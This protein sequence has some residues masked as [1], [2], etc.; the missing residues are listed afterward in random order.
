MKKFYTIICLTFLT[1]FAFSQENSITGFV[2][3]N[4]SGDP[5][6]AA[7]VVVKETQK[8]TVTA[9]NGYFEI[10]VSGDASVI[11]QVTY[12][13]YSTIEIKATPGEK[14]IIINMEPS[15]IMGD[16]VVVS[17]SRFSENI[18]TAPLTI[19]KINERQIESAPSGDYFQSLGNLRDVEIINN[20][21]GFKIFNSRGFNTTA[22][23][24]VVQ[25]I[26]GIDNQLPTINIVPGNMFGVSDI[27][28]R[29][30]EV[31]SGPASALYGPNAMQGVISYETKNPYDFPGVTVKLKGGNREYF[32]GQFRAAS[33]FIN[34]KLGVK[35]AGSYMK[36][37]DWQSDYIYGNQPAH[38]M[39][40]QDIMGQMLQDPSYSDF[41]NYFT[42]VDQNTAPF[43]KVIMPGYS[44]ED[45]FN[46]KIDNMKISG[47]L[48]Y[49]FSKDIQAK[50]VYRYSTGTSL[51]M[52]NNRAPLDGFYQQLHSLEFKGKGFTFHAYRSDD[53][54][55]DTYTLVGAGVNLGF[56]SLG[57]VDA[58]F[59][60]AYVNEIQSLSN[61][62]TNTLTPEQLTQAIAAGSTASQDSWLEPGT[63]T[64]NTAYDKIKET[65]PP[66]G[67]HYSS[68]T[69]LY[70][71]GGMYEYS[72]EKIDLNVGGSY[73]NTKPVSHGSVFAD[74]LQQDGS[75]RQIDVSEYG[76]FV[77]GIGHIS[78]GKT[79]LYASIRM[80]KSKN[81]DWQFSPRIAVVTTAGNNN[82]RLTL[83]SAFRAPAVSDQYQYLNRGRDI[84]LG[85]VDG[86]GNCY[87][88]SSIDS[89][90]ANGKDPALLVSTFVAAV[91]PEQVKSIE[92]GYN[93]IFGEKLYVDFSAYFSMYSDFIAYQRVGRPGFGTAGEPSG[94]IAMDTNNY[95][96]YSVAT[97]VEQDVNTYGASIGLGYYFS[98]KIMA[99]VNYTYSNIDSAGIS[100]DVIPGFNTPKHKVNMGLEGTN[101][102][103]NL[104][105]VVNWKWVD[106]Y[107]WEAVFASG[108]V[109]S[110]NTLDIQLNYSF[111]E[112]YST[113]RLGGSNILGQ[114]YIQAYAMPQ[115]GA[116]WYASWTFDLN[117]KK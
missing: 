108:P 89:Y 54:T 80:D 46:G 41:V 78:D 76:G 77:Q 28:I 61:N 2:Y 116:F 91:K 53:N 48:Y 16:E 59:L 35:I 29:N 112:L 66:A 20:S 84:V 8:G 107:Y 15:A 25:L 18:R 17:A 87:T 73:R 58:T 52:G 67:A 74:T 43:T 71:V 63:E 95:Q 68:K 56:A 55:S 47:A 60:P 38:P 23:L 113:L 44:E 22:P 75:Y 37:N 11:L 93:G 33:T 50:Y 42:T 45:L 81:Y 72:F 103:K 6:A 5:L 65:P 19:Q 13:G 7:N 104:G 21:I 9:D 30:I 105:F 39:I 115:I 110:Y 102:Y 82:F 109:P 69:T 98:E 101:V 3:D 34:D 94:I 90:Y 79:K 62:F 83:Q 4:Q 100:Q 24:R 36:A 88:Q 12:I 85:N 97:N 114:E 117:F 86:F 10:K 111:P 49:K 14:S 99:Y 1:F 92:F 57:S 64:F 70:H 106:D 51:F 40:Q 26:D 96:K 27:D 31:I 32:E